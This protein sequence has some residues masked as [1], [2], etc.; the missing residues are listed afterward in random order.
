MIRATLRGFA[1]GDFAVGLQRHDEL[2]LQVVL[3][4]LHIVRRG[5]PRVVERI[6]ELDLVMQAHM[7]R[8]AAAL[9]LADAAAALPIAGLGIMIEL[10]LRD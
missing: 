8:H 7:W 2:L 6:A 9:I 10:G 3:D 4:E 1:Q 5:V